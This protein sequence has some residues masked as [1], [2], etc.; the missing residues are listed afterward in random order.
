M[1]SNTYIFFSFA[2]CDQ[3]LDVGFVIDSS[4]SINPGD[5]TLCL[6]FVAKLAKLF[7][8]SEH[9]THFGAIIYS[10]TAE[11]EF[12]FAY[13]K[14]YNTKRLQ[15]A[16]RQFPYLAT[17]T[18]TDLGLERANTDLF[19]KEGGDRPDKPNVLIVITD[20]RTNPTL[21][22]PYA[23]VLKP[24]QVIVVTILTLRPS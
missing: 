5:Y 23:E 20:G 1:N 18:R 22:K 12:N 17:G 15:K 3:V 21:S 16:I 2:E 6:D 8:V 13:A 9:G 4:D 19:S 11:L 24:L 10:S 14:Y 7:K